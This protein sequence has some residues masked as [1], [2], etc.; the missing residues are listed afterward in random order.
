MRA[1]RDPGQTLLSHF[2]GKKTNAKCAMD[3]HKM[4]NWG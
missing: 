2:T 1:M 4:L 3:R